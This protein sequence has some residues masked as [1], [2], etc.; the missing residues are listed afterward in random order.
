MISNDCV[1]KIL[2]SEKEATFFS[3]F[4]CVLLTKNRLIMDRFVAASVFTD[5]ADINVFALFPTACV[6]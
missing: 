5:A 1:I 3:L 4:S 2:C 6:N